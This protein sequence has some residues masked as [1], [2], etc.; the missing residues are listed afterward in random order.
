MSTSKKLV[1]VYNANSDMGSKIFDAAHK[2][3]NPKTYQCNLCDI[4]YGAF[5]EKSVWKS[6][7]K[8]TDLEMVFLHKDEFSE[9]YNPALIAGISFPVVLEETRSDLKVLIKTDELNDIKQPVEL[10]DLITQRF[11]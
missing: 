6:F 8:N 1:F 2:I 9:A 3:L 5:S 11:L 7:R 4:T 10:I